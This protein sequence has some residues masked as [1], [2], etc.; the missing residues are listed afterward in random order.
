MDRVSVGP[1][2]GLKIAVAAFV[3]SVV[4]F[5]AVVGGGLYLAVTQSTE[6]AETH[7]AIC[8]LASDLETRT[9][10]TRVFLKTHP[11]GLPGI[12]SAAQL[13]ESLHNQERTLAALGVVSC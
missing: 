5:A 8:A 12:A 7:E 3:L 11:H 6:G 4:L 10:G 1:V 9:D 2:K 13:R